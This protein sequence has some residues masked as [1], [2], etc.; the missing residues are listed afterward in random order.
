MKKKKTNKQKSVSTVEKPSQVTPWLLI[1]KPIEPLKDS[2]LKIPGWLGVLLLVIGT[3]SLTLTGIKWGLP[4]DRPWNTDSIAGMKTV[5]MLPRLFSSWHYADMDGKPLMRNGKPIIERYPRVQ[6]I[7]TGLIYKQM[8]NSWDPQH[9]ASRDFQVDSKNNTFY[10]KSD[11]GKKLLKFQLSREQISKLIMASRIVIILMAIGTVL[12]VFAVARLLSRNSLVGFLSALVMMLSAE[13]NQFSHIGNLDTPVTFWFIWTAYVVLKAI[14][15][16]QFRYF[17]LTGLFAAIAMGTKDPIVGS[18]AALAL[19]MVGCAVFYHVRHGADLSQKLKFLYEPRLWGSL[20]CFVALICLLNNVWDTLAFK[21]RL[22]HWMSVKEDYQGGAGHQKRLAFKALYCIRD[23]CGIWM[24]WTIIVSF[25]YCLWRHRLCALWAIFPFVAFHLIVTVDASQ[26]QA[27]YHLPSLACM[28]ILVGL[29]FRDLLEL[30]RFPLFVKMIPLLLIYGIATVFSASISL[31]MR[32]ESRLRAEAWIREN[33][34]K[35]KG[36]ITF[37]SPPSYMPRS[38]HEGYNVRYSL[39]KGKTDQRSIQ[40][41]PQ[42][43]ALSNKWYNDKLFFDQKFKK[44]L[45]NEQLGYKKVEVFR[46]QYLNPFGQGIFKIAAL[47]TKRRS[48]ISP[49]VVIMER[50]SD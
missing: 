41:K 15:T 34:D 36:S 13:F 43:I 31:E 20:I 2:V 9:I 23:A 40:H 26:V 30:K 49:V 18:L 45:L 32:N 5:N 11:D 19:F 10:A 4:N 39:N 48:V 17:V 42:Y 38:Q 25:F 28:A 47:K 14:M 33:I 7:I 27:R 21:T 12:G 22:D 46:P 8:I 1:D 35:E 29:A 37:I 24:F 16:L 44:Q 6:F 3:L 50:I